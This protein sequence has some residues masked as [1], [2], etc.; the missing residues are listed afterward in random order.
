MKTAKSNLWLH[1][2]KLSQY[3]L[4]GP[5]TFKQI[6]FERVKTLQ[7]KVVQIGLFCFGQ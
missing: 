3:S 6:V 2:G 5:D 4:L 7:H 1:D